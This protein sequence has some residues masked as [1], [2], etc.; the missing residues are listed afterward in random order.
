MEALLLV[1]SDHLLKFVLVLTRLSGLL[2]LS[3]IWSQPAIPMRVRAFLA[4]G[5]AM[6]ITPLAAAGEPITCRTLLDLAALASRELAVGLCLGLA[7][8]LYFSG[9]QL[10]GQVM[11]QMS[12]M[13]LT[14]VVDPTYGSGVP[15]FSR[16]L[17]LLMLALFLIIGGHRAVLGALLGTFERMPPGQVRWS[18]SWLDGLV[19]IIQNSFVLGLQ[20]AA[21]IMVALMLSILIMGL[22]SRTLPQLNILAVGFSVNAL[23]MLGAFLLSLGVLVRVFEARCLEPLELIRPLLVGG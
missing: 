11:G 16:L 14:D 4:I 10:A 15:V 8:M 20:L 17:Q 19:Q 5:L 23:V 18:A 1:F 3:P 6:I 9:L 2:V 21:P 13:S 12:G 22:I 7:V